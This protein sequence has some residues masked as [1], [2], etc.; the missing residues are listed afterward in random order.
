MHSKLHLAEH[1]D[2]FSNRPV[3]KIDDRRLQVLCDSVALIFQ[4]KQSAVATVQLDFE[5]KPG[6]T[7]H[8]TALP[9][10]VTDDCGGTNDT[11]EISFSVYESKDLGAIRIKVPSEFVESPHTF[12]LLDRSKQELYG[13]ARIASQE[14]VIENLVPGD[15]NAV[16]GSDTN[17]NGRMDPM[18]L[19]PKVVAER[20]H[21]FPGTIE[22]R[23]NWEVVV[24]WPVQD[25]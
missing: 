1:T 22:I 2:F 4:S 13:V 7:Y 14:W 6:K 18:I 11:L 5:K 19:Y 17:A 9:G 25:K 10:Y 24:D 12:K 16:V 8:L 3:S 23:P 15:Y 21:L 20:N